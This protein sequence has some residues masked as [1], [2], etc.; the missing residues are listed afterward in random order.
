MNVQY[1]DGSLGKTIKEFK[2]GGPDPI[3]SAA[4]V[5]DS[6]RPLAEF[7]RVNNRNVDKIAVDKRMWS[8][9]EKMADDK[10]DGRIIRHMD[11]YPMYGKY[12][13]VRLDQ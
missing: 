1:K 4:S 11:G 5:I 8:R 10:N 12:Q 13:L 9:V 3:P 6:I 7:Y 2:D